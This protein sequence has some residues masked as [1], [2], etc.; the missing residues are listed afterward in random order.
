[1]SQLNGHTIKLYNKTYYITPLGFLLWLYFA[2][3]VT[4]SSKAV[5][6]SW[7]ETAVT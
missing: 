4:V 7:L 2:C 6:G 5:A 1:M 3:F